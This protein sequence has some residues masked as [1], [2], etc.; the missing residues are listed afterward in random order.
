MEAASDRKVTL[1]SGIVAAGTSDIECTAIPVAGYVDHEFIAA[2]GTITATAVTAL[3]IQESDAS[4]GSFTEVPVTQVDIA[5]TDDDTAFSIRCGAHDL[6]ADTTHIR[7]VVERG[8]ANA[9]LDAA[10]VLQRK[11]TM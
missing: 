3:V 9:E 10:V 6:K 8:T 2:L 11:M 1:C 5:A 7:L 4:D